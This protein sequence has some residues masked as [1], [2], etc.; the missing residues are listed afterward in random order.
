M[1]DSARPFGFGVERMEIEELDSGKKDWMAWA[2][3]PLWPWVGSMLSG[4]LLAAGFPG[5]GSSESIVYMA[6]V[7]LMFAAQM[8]S[9]RRAIGL[10]FFSGAIFFLLTLGW[11]HNLTGTVDTFGMKLSAL[12][13]YAVLS[14]YCALYFIPFSWTV[15]A[16]VHHWGTDSFRSNLRTM[17]S[18]TVV[19]VASEYLRSTLFTGFPWNALGISQYKSPAIIQVAEWGGVYLVSACIVWMNAA[20]FVTLLQYFQGVRSKK[21]RPHV[22]LMLGLFPLALCVAHGF[23]TLVN[24]PII[25]GKPLRVTL[26]QPNISQRDKWSNEKEAHIRTRLEELT[27]TAARLG[28]TD[29]V[30]WPETALPDFVRI[31]LESQQLVRRMVQL[32]S[33]LLVGGLDIFL[34]DGERAYSNSSILFGTNGTMLAK[35]D[36]QHLVPFGEYVP[37][38][39]L[40]GKF[41]PVEVDLRPGTQSTLMELPDAPPFSS[42][43]CF[44]DT[45]APLAVKAVRGGARWLV[46][47]SND[48]WFDPSAESEQHLAH[49]VFRCVENRV[50]MARCCNSG[51]SCVIDAYGNIIRPLPA[52]T[53]GFRTL[54]IQPRPIGLAK[55]LYTFHG[56]IFAKVSLL[57]AAT[58][59]FA[60][61]FQGRKKTIRHSEENAG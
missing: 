40:L 35:Y 52:R 4:V 9:P 6:L 36:K 21:Y 55:T 10:G 14:L 8:V 46:N 47:Q 17:F 38:H 20:I 12:L 53:S 28:P 49:A 54:Q 25:F 29:L 61:R 22:E 1:G 27:Q 19:W 43:I 31:S 57:A 15:S 48:A 41:S 33:P 39:R 50:P 11:L 42:L 26:I 16:C 24:R 5:T 59:L 58:L 32:G 2:K 18:A 44:E 30:I 51:I 60:L 56:D 13:G 37:F 34:V 3:S 45:V 23:G 7:P